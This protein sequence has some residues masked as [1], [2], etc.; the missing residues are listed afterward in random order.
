MQGDLSFLVVK[1]QNQSSFYVVGSPGRFADEDNKLLDVQYAKKLSIGAIHTIAE[2][3]ASPSDDAVVSDSTS[4]S[5]EDNYV[6]NT[7]YKTAE[8]FAT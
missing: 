5:G 6:L 7:F 1:Y 2:A 4:S 3:M 8:G